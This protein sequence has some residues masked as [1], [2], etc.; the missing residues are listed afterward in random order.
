LRRITILVAIAAAGILTGAAGCS[1]S[2]PASPAITAP[3]AV[4]T[5]TPASDPYAVYL[6]NNPRADLVLSRED[7][8]T[9]AILG[10][11]QTFAPG[12]VDR[13]LA[14]AYR[15]MGICDHK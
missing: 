9:R 12:T 6:K 14:E 1:T 3:A 13:V 4:A 7:A 15:P 8:Q 5:T 10:C 11:G 2:A